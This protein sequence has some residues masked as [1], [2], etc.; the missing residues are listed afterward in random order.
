MTP[1]TT[2]SRTWPPTPPTQSLY[3]HTRHW[4]QAHSEPLRTLLPWRMVSSKERKSPCKFWKVAKFLTRYSDIFTC[5]VLFI[6][7]FI[8]NLD[9]TLIHHYMCFAIMIIWMEIHLNFSSFKSHLKL[10]TSCHFEIICW[11]VRLRLGKVTPIW[12]CMP[13]PFHSVLENKMLT[14]FVA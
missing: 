1:R 10:F 3:A 5:T 12:Y 8:M 6:G 7:S 9:P 4:P 13:I 11:F 14:P 2:P